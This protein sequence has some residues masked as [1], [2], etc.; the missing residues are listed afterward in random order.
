MTNHK[1]IRGCDRTHH[2]FAPELLGT[3][4]RNL[5]VRDANVEEGVT[6]VTRSASDAPA[7]ACPIL[8][9]KKFQEPV[10]VRSRYLLRHRRGRVEFPA[11]EVAEVST[12][13][14]RILT[15][16]LEV[17]DRLWH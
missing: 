5:D 7:D 9:R 2:T 17:H 1:A 6:L 12:K 13:P 8:G 16:D 11:K 15:D 3:L 4:Q 10:T 14:L